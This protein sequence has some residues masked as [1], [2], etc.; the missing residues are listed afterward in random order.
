MSY[1]YRATW[2]SYEL[3]LFYKNYLSWLRWDYNTMFI[4]TKYILY[5]FP[6]F[7]WETLSL[8][9]LKYTCA[10][11]FILLLWIKR[12][13]SMLMNSGTLHIFDYSLVQ[14]TVYLTRLLF[15]CFIIWDSGFS[16][17]SFKFSI[18]ILRLITN[19]C[20]DISIPIRKALYYFD[21]FHKLLQFCDFL[22][23]TLYKE[24]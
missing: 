1:F 2:F 11:K 23:L 4:R 17:W 6:Y 8:W 10:K 24:F 22:W 5:W 9:F 7:S 20:V 12:I 21:Q 16:I 15:I 18:I 14:I 19:N 13:S 3:I